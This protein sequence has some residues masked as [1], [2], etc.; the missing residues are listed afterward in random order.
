MYIYLPKIEYYI[1]YKIPAV[2]KHID[3]W[4]ILRKLVLSENISE[5][6]VNDIIAK[7][8]IITVQSKTAIVPRVTE[9]QTGINNRKW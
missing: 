9:G 3:T 5:V 7:E 6:Y 1:E 8:D 2:A 4:E